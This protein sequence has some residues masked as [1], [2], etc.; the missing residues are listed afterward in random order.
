MTIFDELLLL[1]AFINTVALTNSEAATKLWG[2][3]SVL[4]TRLAFVGSFSK[5][6]TGFLLCVLVHA[7]ACSEK[8]LVIVRPLVCKLLS[9]LRLILMLRYLCIRRF[10]LC[11][12]GWRIHAV[13]LDIN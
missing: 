4:N 10:C 8:Y 6:I 11:L 3:L 13:L 2:I 5:V 7:M 9:F 12:G 1:L